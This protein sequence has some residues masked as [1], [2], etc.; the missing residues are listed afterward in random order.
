MTLRWLSSEIAA[1]FS[2]KASFCFLVEDTW[3][4]PSDIVVTETPYRVFVAESSLYYAIASTEADEHGIRQIIRAVK[5]FDY[6]GFVA[7]CQLLSGPRISNLDRVVVA[8][9]ARCIRMAAVS[10]FDREGMIIS[11]TAARPA[12]LGGPFEPG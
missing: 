7:S 12:A 6:T 8:E 11:E 3:A 10:A 9:L 2:E 4:K 5:G 1:R